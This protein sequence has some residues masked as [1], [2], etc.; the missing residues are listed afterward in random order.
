M[1]N[2]NKGVAL[3]AL[4]AATGC[5]PEPAAFLQTGKQVGDDTVVTLDNPDFIQVNLPLTPA[6]TKWNGVMPREIDVT[7]HGFAVKNGDFEVRTWRGD[8]PAATS[9]VS[10]FGSVSNEELPARPDAEGHYASDQPPAAVA[11]HAHGLR[12]G[13]KP[14]LVQL[15]QIEPDHSSPTRFTTLRARLD[16]D[17]ALVPIEAVVLFH[18]KDAQGHLTGMQQQRLPQQLAVWDHMPAVETTNVT[19]G[20]YGELTSV[21]HAMRWHRRDKD[22][23]YAV[24]TQT[25]PDTVWGF[26]GVQFRL[27]NYFELQVPAR[28]VFPARG[29]ADENPDQ[30][31]PAETHDDRPL[32]ENLSRVQRDPRHRNGTVVAIFMQRVGFADAPEVGRALV[33]SNAIGVSLTDNRSTKGVLAH[34]LGHLS[35]LRDGDASAKDA[36]GN[37]L[38][39]VMVNPGPGVKP[40]AAECDPIK[41]WAD[42]FKGFWTRPPDGREP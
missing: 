19:E 28:N 10:V 34:E 31:W 23:Q 37:P 13:F 36:A 8:G 35:G 21:S 1:K 4:L 7:A 16:P 32:R 22:L 30:F 20:Q 5:D 9:G 27:V 29:N 24:G 3:A 2:L 26:C 39:D 41:R 40:T 12:V 14:L 42:S 18:E 11:L 25:A 15:F 6:K 17:V 38:F 33:G